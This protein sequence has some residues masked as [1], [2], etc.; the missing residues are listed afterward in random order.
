MHNNNNINVVKITGYLRVFAVRY[1][2]SKRTHAESL[3]CYELS[4][5]WLLWHSFLKTVYEWR[6]PIP[7]HFLRDDSTSVE[8]E[9]G[10]FQPNYYI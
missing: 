7:I 3:T 5:V 2:F 8:F 4:S 1:K 9:R 10:Y 6:N